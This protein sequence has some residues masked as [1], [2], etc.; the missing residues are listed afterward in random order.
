MPVV[1]EKTNSVSEQ[2]INKVN[3]LTSQQQ[4]ELMKNV[5]KMLRLNWCKELNDSVEP[6][7]ITMEEIVAITKEVRRADDKKNAQ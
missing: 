7:N 4:N 2:I 5:D 1:A 6:N 3:L